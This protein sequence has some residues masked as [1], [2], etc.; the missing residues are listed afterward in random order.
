MAL[1]YSYSKLMK[2]LNEEKQKQRKD[3]I[4]NIDTIGYSLS[5]NIVPMLNVSTE[6]ENKKIIVITAR[7][8]P[9]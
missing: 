9:G 6:G 3:V 1:P 5:N 8:H 4:L 7:Q 2:F